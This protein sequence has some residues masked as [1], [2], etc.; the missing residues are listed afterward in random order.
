M[1]RTPKALARRLQSARRHRM[2]RRPW[3]E[4]AA[5]P[6]AGGVNAA[7]LFTEPFAAGD[8][9]AWLEPDIRRESGSGC[10]RY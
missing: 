3:S 4:A 5:I 8:T 6:E 7:V 1:K 9:A 2:R 10:S